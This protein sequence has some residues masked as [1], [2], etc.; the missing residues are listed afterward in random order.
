VLVHGLGGSLLNWAL[1]APGLA[2]LGR[3]LALDLPG[4]GTSPRAG[5][6]SGLMDQRRTLSAFANELATG[7][8][9]VVGNSMGGATAMLQAAVEPEAV[10]A[11]VLTC[12]VFPWARGGRPHPLILSAFA[13]YRSP[14]MGEWLADRR[15]HSLD[16]EQAVRMSFRLIAADPASVPDELIRLMVE[17]VEGRQNDRDAGPAF[18][19]AAR[20]MLRLG[21]RPDLAARA[22]DNVRCPVLVLHGRRDRLVPAAFAEAALRRHPAWRGRIFADLG[23]VPQIEA[24][25]RWLAA[26]ADWFADV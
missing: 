11:L 20:S 16:P 4:F 25:G 26:V 21:A 19:D 10:D 14:A 7:R 23:H 18:L 22:M 1:V 8:V 6:G 9:V 15:S 13:M 5:R 24:P 3:V 2:G 12:S 17:Q